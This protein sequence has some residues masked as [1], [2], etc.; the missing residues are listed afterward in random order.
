LS[1]I[2]SQPLFAIVAVD[3]QKCWAV[4]PPATSICI[5]NEVP[6][7]GSPETTVIMDAPD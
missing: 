7:R 4:M 2:V 1:S 3:L 6:E 5:I